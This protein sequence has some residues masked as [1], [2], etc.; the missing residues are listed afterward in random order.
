MDRRIDRQIDECTNAPAAAIIM[1]TEK[2]ST[3]E[4]R[5]LRLWP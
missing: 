1:A 2:Q 5:E 4:T 3:F